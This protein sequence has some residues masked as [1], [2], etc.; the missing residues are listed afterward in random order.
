[1]TLEIKVERLLRLAVPRAALYDKDFEALFAKPA[2]RVVSGG[3]T[4]FVVC[5]IIPEKVKKPS[6]TMAVNNHLDNTLFTGRNFII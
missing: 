2:T 1:M 3:T 6:I 4:L 5:I